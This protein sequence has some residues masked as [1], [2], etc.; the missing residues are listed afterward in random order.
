MDVLDGLP[1]IERDFRHVP[2]GFCE[3]IRDQGA[4]FRGLGVGFEGGNQECQSLIRRP[5][6]R[7][8]DAGGGEFGIGG[9]GGGCRCGGFRR[10]T[11]GRQGAEREHAGG[12]DALVAVL[13]RVIFPSLHVPRFQRRKRGIVSVMSAFHDDGAGL[14]AAFLMRARSWI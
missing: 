7:E 6:F 8:V 5:G 4:G 13:G 10:F 12:R 14:Q 9:R 3:S 1:V 11:G 2:A